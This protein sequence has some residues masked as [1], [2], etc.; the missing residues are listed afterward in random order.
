MKKNKENRM[1]KPFYIS[2][3]LILF[4]YTCYAQNNSIISLS[5]EQQQKAA[6][7][8]SVLQFYHKEG[9]LNGAVLVAENRK[10][11]YKNAFGYANFDTKDTLNVQSVFRLASVSKQFTAMCIMIL[12]ERGKLSYDDNITKHLPELKYK[13]VTIR[14]LL[15]HTGGLSEGNDLWDKH[16]DKN[17]LAG[18]DDVLQLITKYR[19]K[20]NFAPGEKYAY[21]NIGYIFLATIVR[22][23]SG[24]P[25]RQFVRENIFD[26]L[27][28][29]NSLVPLG[30][31]DEKFRNRV[32]GFIRDP[33]NKNQYVE[34]DY[35]YGNGCVGDGGV[36]STV[37]DLFKWN[38]ALYTDKLVK[39]ETIEEAFKP[40]VLNDG[41]IG[42]YGFGWSIYQIDSNNITDH[43]GSWLGFRTYNLRDIT[44]K[45]SVIILTNLGSSNGTKLYKPC[46]RILR[47]SHDKDWK[48]NYF[49]KKDLKSKARATF[50]KISQ[51]SINQYQ[52]LYIHTSETDTSKFYVSVK[53]EIAILAN[54]NKS[55]QERI[56][57][58]D[59]V[60]FINKTS[61]NK[62]SFRFSADGRILGFI[63]KS[64]VS[65][66]KYATKISPEATPEYMNDL[67]ERYVY[68]TYEVYFNYHNGILRVYIPGDGTYLLIPKSDKKYIF[69]NW[70]GYSVKFTTD[71]SNSIIEKLE[72]I[73]P[74]Q[75]MHLKHQNKE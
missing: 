70:P 50:Q 56:Y 37:E 58:I 67:K 34:N 21:S 31:R 28:M 29:N 49:A 51:N 38:E 30:Y 20:I 47:G 65:G 63:G 25:F 9:I 23:I 3:S 8:D 7:I 24:I 52:G 40:Y 68:G 35:N 26:P 55:A 62:Y 61:N 75:T 39:K 11:I 27:E 44:D 69:P 43:S 10:V 60:H 18:N 13:D 15:W 54:I 59:S 1:L 46:Y 32:I 57:P 16:W 66:V 73:T 72:Y 45:H 4:L 2:I 41:T 48:E 17:K 42:D 22:R 64:G 53:D 33:N 5:P 74:E 14:H 6:E 71:K 12:N 19:P 36:Y